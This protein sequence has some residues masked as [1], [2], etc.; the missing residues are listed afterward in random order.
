MK[1]GL[2][3]VI[4]DLF[5]VRRLQVMHEFL[6]LCGQVGQGFS[7]GQGEVPATFVSEE[8]L[9]QPIRRFSADFVRHQLIGL[10]PQTIALAVCVILE[11][12]LNVNLTGTDKHRI[13]T[14]PAEYNVEVLVYKSRTQFLDYSTSNISIL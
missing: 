12:V 3:P 5:V 11:E 10:M 9:V 6:G 13:L 4:E 2:Q 14:V 1:E 7:G 8:T